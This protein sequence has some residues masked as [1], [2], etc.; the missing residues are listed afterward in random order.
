[1]RIL[2]AVLFTLTASIASAANAPLAMVVDSHNALSGVA[3]NASA[4]TRTVTA[5]FGSPTSPS[6]FTK[7]R[8]SVFFTWA[9]ASTVTAVFS[10]SIDGTN[11]ASLT[12]RSITAG[13]SAVSIVTDTYTTGGASADIMLEYDI[14]GCRA[15]KVLLGG[16]SA[17]A[18]DLVTVDWSAIVGG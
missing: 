4:A 5:V 18:T 11:Y 16:A 3:L 8:V 15:A 12:S 6:P 17:G 14:Q 7:W 2:A 10:C 9:A 13:A 1:M